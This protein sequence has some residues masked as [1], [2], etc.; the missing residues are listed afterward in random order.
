MNNSPKK[1]NVVADDSTTVTIDLQTLLIPASIILSAIIISLSIFLSIRGLAATGIVAGSNTTV[2]PTQGVTDGSGKTTI[3]DDPIQGDKSTAKIAIVEYSDYECP[4]CKM[5][6]QETYADL[7]KTYVN[8]GKAIYVYRDF[9]AVTGHNPMATNE[10]IAAECVDELSSDKNYYDFHDYLF[11]NTSSNGAGISG[12]KDAYIAKALTY[13]IDKTAYTNCLS[14]AKIANE[15]KSDE[16][17][18]VAAGINGT[19]G[20]IIGKLDANGNV[21]GVIVSGAQPVASF[22]QVIDEQLAK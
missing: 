17:A 1:D 5:F 13:G 8:T 2:T 20:F 9:I 16:E 15:V 11:N 6:A 19:P 3:D 18:A 22:K 14:D 21:D 12:G 7:I 10:A 4:Y